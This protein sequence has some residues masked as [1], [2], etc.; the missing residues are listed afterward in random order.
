MNKFVKIV[1]PLEVDEEGFPPISC[2][3]LNARSHPPGFVLEN[4]PFFVTGVALGDHVTGVPVH[5]TNSRFAFTR[6]IESSPNKAIS[7]IFLD[8]GLKDTVYQELK[9]RGCYCEYGEFGKG[10]DL[11]MLA[12][13]VPEE[14]DYASLVAYLSEIEAAERLSFAELAV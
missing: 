14:C 5:G 11:Q 10:P 13:A 1:F 4:S 7:I 9:R 12:V 6:V 3:V 2:E 8:I